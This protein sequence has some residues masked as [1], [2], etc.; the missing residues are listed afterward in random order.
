MQ[1]LGAKLLT[2]QIVGPTITMQGQNHGWTRRLLL[3][4]V[5]W[6]FARQVNIKTMW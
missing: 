4:F 5:T 2:N 3:C 1:L 6:R